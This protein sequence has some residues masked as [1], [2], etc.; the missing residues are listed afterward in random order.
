MTENISHQ[1]ENK[2]TE[3]GI[4]NYFW[5]LSSPVEK[6]RLDAAE[7]ILKSLVDAQLKFNKNSEKDPQDLSKKRCPDFEYCL[8][9]LIR[10]LSSSRQ[11]SRQ[12]FC[13]TLTEIL[14]EFYEY[15]EIS[16]IFEMMNKFIF[17]SN[18]MKNS[19][20]QDA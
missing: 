6:N 4:L 9:R 20:Q 5:E 17:I 16:E 11:G 19:Q 15:I 18:G 3:S 14:R 2:K 8:G 10:G 12:G 1:H 13:L 7:G